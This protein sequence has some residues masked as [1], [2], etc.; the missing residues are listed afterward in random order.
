VSYY[1]LEGIARI[2][3]ILFIPILL[4]ILV[5][6]LLAV[7][8]YDISYLKPYGGYGL[9]KTLFNGVLGSSNFIEVSTVWLFLNSLHGIKNA[10]KAG[11]IGLL[12]SVRYTVLWVLCYLMVLYIYNSR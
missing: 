5:I 10:K 4:G 12:I 6:L 11:I 9:K 3:G 8:N 1:G 7:P 2:S